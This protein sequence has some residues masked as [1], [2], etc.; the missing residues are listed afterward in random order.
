MMHFDIFCHHNAAAS[1]GGARK[2]SR[3][4]RVAPTQSTFRDGDATPSRGNLQFQMLLLEGA[5]AFLP[6]EM[7]S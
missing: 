7:I 5:N 4:Q 1:V 3:S 6:L 2:R